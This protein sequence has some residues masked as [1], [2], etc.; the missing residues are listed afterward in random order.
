MLTMRVW[1]YEV[2]LEWQTSCKWGK[3]FWPGQF[4]TWAY[5]LGRVHIA[6]CRLT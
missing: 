2:M 3:E 1:Q 6:V 5:W 4:P